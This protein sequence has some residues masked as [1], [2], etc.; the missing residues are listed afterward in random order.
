MERILLHISLIGVRSACSWRFCV[1]LMLDFDHDFSTWGLCS[2][3]FTLQES[4]PVL[5]SDSLTNVCHN[6]LS[7]FFVKTFISKWSS[8]R[9]P[10][11][12]REHKCLVFPISGRSPKKTTAQGAKISRPLRLPCLFCFGS[13]LLAQTPLTKKGPS[14]ETSEK[15]F[16]EESSKLDFTRHAGN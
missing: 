11:S 7:P 12:Q 4:S 6:T 10:A 1:A 9:S 15:C 14:A 5:K 13:S 2:H 3:L 16:M 8:S